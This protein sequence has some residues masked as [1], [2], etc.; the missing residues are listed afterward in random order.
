MRNNRDDNINTKDKL[1]GNGLYV[2]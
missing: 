1:I 2:N